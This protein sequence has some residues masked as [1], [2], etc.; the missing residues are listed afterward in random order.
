[1]APLLEAFTLFD[2]T[3]EKIWYISLLLRHNGDNAEGEHVIIALN[4]PLS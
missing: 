3:W 1:M 4:F 2:R